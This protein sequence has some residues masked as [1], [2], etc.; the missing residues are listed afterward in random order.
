[1]WFPQGK[2][3]VKAIHSMGL[4]WVWKSLRVVIEG[5]PLGKQIGQNIYDSIG[6]PVLITSNLY[7]M[8]LVHTILQNN[9]LFTLFGWYLYFKV[10]R[11]LTGSQ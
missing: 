7:P 10:Y 4:N 9:P 11:I 8:Q 1:M 5:I 2:Y 6:E 3:Y